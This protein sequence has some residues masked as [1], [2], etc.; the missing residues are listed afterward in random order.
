MN[1][2]DAPRETHASSSSPGT[3]ELLPPGPP[4]PVFLAGIPPGSSGLTIT[5]AIREAAL[6]ATDFSWLSRGDRV[7]IK[8]ALNSGNPYPATTSPLAIAAMV[9]LL[10][11]KGAGRILVGDMS[12]IE[13]VK[14]SPRKLTGSTRELME[15]SGMAAAVRAAGAHIA[16]FEEAG[17]NA[18]YEELPASGAHWKRGLMMPDVLKEADHII[19]MPR[20]A[21]HVLAGSSL[22]LKCAVGYWRTDTRLEYHRD[23][24]SFQEKTAEGN[25]VPTL[26]KKQRLVL[27]LADQVLTSFGPDRG[28]V[29]RPDPGLVIAA[30]SVVAHDMVSLGWLLENRRLTPSSATGVLHDPY[31]AQWMVSLGNHWIVSKLGS[32]RQALASERLARNDIDSIW[33]DRVLSHACRIFGGVPQLTL[34]AVN[35]AGAVVAA[36]LARQFTTPSRKAA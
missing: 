9:E 15:A 18:F 13:H 32:W 30:D 1:R 8:P 21:R 16:L 7:F 19:L 12:G 36:S 34:K 28:Y 35:E 27:S 29:I 4:A 14:L 33:D 3:A 6:A 11:E 5:T 25:T 23:A 22:G 31:N 20:C 2:Q 24:A 26:L 10:R 17:W